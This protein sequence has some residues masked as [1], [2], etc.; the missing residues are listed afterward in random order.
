MLVFHWWSGE[1]MSGGILLQW[2]NN[3]SLQHFWLRNIKPS[4]GRWL[5]ASRHSRREEVVL[6]RL[7]LS[8]CL[9]Q[10]K[11]YFD[12]SPRIFCAVYLVPRTIVHALIDCPQF[13]GLGLL[14]VVRINLNWRF[15]W[16][17]VLIMPICFLF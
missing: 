1:L 2:Q 8:S 7:Q 13:A 9:F 12:K 5:S 11:H 16:E 15:C 4:V 3:W 6:S 14:W 17:M 10:V